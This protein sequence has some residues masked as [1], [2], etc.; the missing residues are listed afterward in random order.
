MYLNHIVKDLLSSFPV[1]L[2]YG[3]KIDNKSHI[4]ATS[5]PPPDCSVSVHPPAMAG[6]LSA[7]EG[8]GVH[9]LHHPKD[10]PVRI[11]C[12]GSAEGGPERY[13][14]KWSSNVLLHDKLARLSVMEFNASLP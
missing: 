4:C 10:D 2:R 14:R 8:L 6:M 1:P 11:N 3:N 9:V 12:E 7:Q 5:S 13:D